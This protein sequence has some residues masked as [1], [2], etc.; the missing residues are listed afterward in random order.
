MNLNHKHIV[1]FFGIVEEENHFGIILK[2][3][4]GGNLEDL[5]RTNKDDFSWTIR[6][7]ILT[8]ISDA[9]NY[10]HT[11]ADKPLIH[12][13]LKPQNILLTRR[14]NVRLGDLGSII[15]EVSRG[16]TQPS[17]QHTLEYTPPERLKD[18][19]E[20]SYYTDIYR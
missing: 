11:H 13:D 5:M 3:V 9:L 4:H 6:L 17:T 1:K 7:K 16:T 10:L 8:Q 14:Y 18:L 2:M 19:T 20:A 12:G 15:A